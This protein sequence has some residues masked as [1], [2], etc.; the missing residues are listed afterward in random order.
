MLLVKKRKESVSVTRLNRMIESD[1]AR[2]VPD[3]PL[4]RRKRER[5]RERNEKEKSEKRE[6]ERE[7]R[8]Y[9][10]VKEAKRRGR[11]NSR[12]QHQVQG[13][14]EADS[15]HFTGRES[16]TTTREKRLR[17]NR[18]P[19]STI[20]LLSTNYLPCLSS[21]TSASLSFS[22]MSIYYRGKTA[23]QPARAHLILLR[24]PCK[25]PLS[26]LWKAI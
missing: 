14:T 16:L 25:T 26:Y 2:P 3:R 17:A 8:G 23:W 15:L 1:R 11:R 22:W 13:L 24:A 21:S 12:I 18:S 4:S 9:T 5:K 19:P 7:E 10:K 20:P 6:R